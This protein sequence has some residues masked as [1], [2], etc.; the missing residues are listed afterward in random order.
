[1]MTNKYE[2]LFGSRKIDF[3]YEGCDYAMNGGGVSTS[4]LASPNAT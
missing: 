4:V 3:L 1:M 2:K